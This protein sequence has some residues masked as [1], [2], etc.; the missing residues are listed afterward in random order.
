MQDTLE[1]AC[2]VSVLSNKVDMLHVGWPYMQVITQYSWFWLGPAQNWP[3]IRKDL[4]S[5]D[6]KSGHHC[7]PISW[8]KSYWTT[9]WCRDLEYNFLSVCPF[10]I[11]TL[12]EREE[13]TFYCQ[14]KPGWLKIPDVLGII[15]ASIRHHVLSFLLNNFLFWVTN[16]ICILQEDCSQS[17][18]QWL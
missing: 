16:I 7:T 9:M 1:P 12:R 14:N 13:D 17:G 4:A 5:V 6:L 2:K 8:V 11:S 15:S 3:Y 10:P 18:G